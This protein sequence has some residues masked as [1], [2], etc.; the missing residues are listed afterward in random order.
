MN[1]PR[2]FLNLCGGSDNSS[3]LSPATGEAV[4]EWVTTGRCIY[5]D[6]AAFNITRFADGRPRGGRYQMH[7]GSHAHGGLPHLGDVQVVLAE[8]QATNWDH[9]QVG[10]L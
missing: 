2:E 7:I 9:G 3:N 10:G 5:L 8:P 4:A 6:T 1:T